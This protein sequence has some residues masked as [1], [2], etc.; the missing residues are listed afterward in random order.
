MT[1]RRAR[2]GG[3]VLVMAIVL[4]VLYFALMELLLLDSARQLQEAQRFR[5][6]IVASNLAESAAELAAEQIFATSSK[7]TG[8]IDDWQ[9]HKIGRMSRTASDPSDPTKPSVF[10]IEA[11]GTTTGVV[12]A[13]SRVHVKGYIA[14]TDIKIDFTEHSQ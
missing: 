7:D 6:R 9:G 2:E 13:T 12:K 5:A 14:G 1:E 8:T 10:E 3:F 4:A 11:S